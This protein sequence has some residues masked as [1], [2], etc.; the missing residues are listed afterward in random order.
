MNSLTIRKSIDDA[1]GVL[2]ARAGVS[3][4]SPVTKKMR[5]AYGYLQ[6]E[7]EQI[8][9]AVLQALEKEAIV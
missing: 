4:S 5:S 1:I 6:V 7:L 9:T 8:D 2:T 3:M